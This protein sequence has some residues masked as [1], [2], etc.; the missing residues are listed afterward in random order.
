MHERL[1]VNEAS[2]KVAYHQFKKEM[3][4]W[5]QVPLRIIT[6]VKYLA[7][8]NLAFHVTNEKLYQMEMFL[9]AIEILQKINPLPLEIPCVVY[10]K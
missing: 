1:H 2:D 7:K 5:K 3:E 9:E 8:Y 10:H 4:H 6:L